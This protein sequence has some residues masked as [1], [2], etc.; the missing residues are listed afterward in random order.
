VW[1][2]KEGRIEHVVRYEEIGMDDVGPTDADEHH[3]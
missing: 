1:L 3:D 2:K